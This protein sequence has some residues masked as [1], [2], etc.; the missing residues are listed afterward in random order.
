MNDDFFRLTFSSEVI[1]HITKVSHARKHRISRLP[2]EKIRRGNRIERIWMLRI[3]F[4]YHHEPVRIVI[5]KRPKQ[6]SVNHTEDGSVGA[7]GH[8]QGQNGD[9]GKAGVLSEVS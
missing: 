8:C 3:V 5:W 7:D 4:P 1:S 2:I 9:S 6:H